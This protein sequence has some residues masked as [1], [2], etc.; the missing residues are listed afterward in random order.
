[1]TNRRCSAVTLI[2]INCRCILRFNSVVFLAVIL[3]NLPFSLLAMEWTDESVNFIEEYME[4]S[5]PDCKLYS[6]QMTVIGDHWFRAD[7]GDI[8][9]L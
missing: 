1:M 7:I 9:S 3:Y 6:E 5:H 4:P 8:G 2:C